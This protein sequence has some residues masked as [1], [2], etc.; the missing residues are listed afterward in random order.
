METVKRHYLAVRA[1]LG[2][3]GGELRAKVLA[4]LPAVEAISAGWDAL[5][6]ANSQPYCA[7]QW[8]L[9]WWRYAAPKNAALRVVAVLDGPRLVAV[10]PMF[11]ERDA[12]NLTRYRMLGAGT[13]LGGQPVAAP[14][15][16]A[17]AAVTIARALI[18]AHPRP[19]IVGFDGVSSSS[20][21]PTLLRDGWPGRRRPWLHSERTM[22]AP[23]L[24]LHGRTY[25]E[26]LASRSRN[27]RQ[28][29]SRRRRGLERQGAVFRLAITPDELERDLESFAV[30][31]YQRWQH[32]GGSGVLNPPVERMLRE[33]SANLAA[34]GRLRLWSLEVGGRC[35]SSQLFVGAGGEL[36]YWLGG[37]DPRWAAHQPA[38]QVLVRALEHAWESGDH[39]VHLGA[40]GQHYKY[41]LADG[42]EAV[43]WSVL[44]P[45]GPRHLVARA[46][47]APRHVWRA[48]L[49][50]VPTPVK[51][52]VKR[53]LGRPVSE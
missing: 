26:W 9:A 3:D 15:L 41:R 51:A 6:V 1:P 7:P 42:E 20:A 17:V 11:C 16:E 46:R 8:M 50:R 2:E 21:W 43:E 36:S 25:G 37:F 34:A 10:A 35:I 31:H 49:A 33:V 14:G 32:R 28:Q 38:L 39:R 29:L 48:A 12:L 27:F 19:D 40:G 53:R 4:D 44:V 30:L 5:A 52:R 18:E 24:H 45:P 23:L 47:L 22:P 13:S